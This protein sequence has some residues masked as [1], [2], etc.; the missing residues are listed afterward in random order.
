[1]LRVIME[2]RASFVMLRDPAEPSAGRTAY[3]RSVDC[4]LVRAANDESFA[5]GIK[6]VQEP[7][8]SFDFAVDGVQINLQGLHFSLVD[9][10]KLGIFRNFDPPVFNLAIQKPDLGL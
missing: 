2:S 9:A 3:D 7:F 8:E 10:D 4:G 5:L 1:M 6:L